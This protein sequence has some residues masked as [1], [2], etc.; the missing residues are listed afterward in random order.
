LRPPGYEQLVA[1]RRRRKPAKPEAPFVGSSALALVA[2]GTWPPE[3]S[4][5]AEPDLVEEPE[6]PASAE[7]A[8]TARDRHERV[9]RFPRA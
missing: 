1:E 2:V 3:D 7:L 9:R 5:V 6:A 8:R 4:P